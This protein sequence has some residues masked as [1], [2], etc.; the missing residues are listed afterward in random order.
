MGQSLRLFWVAN[1]VGDF[2]GHDSGDSMQKLARWQHEWHITAEAEAKQAIATGF[3]NS[4]TE[5]G[6]DP[7][8]AASFLDC[9]NGDEFWRSFRK[10][11]SATGPLSPETGSLA[12]LKWKDWETFIDGMDENEAFNGR[13]FVPLAGEWRAD[14]SA[15][16][17]QIREKRDWVT[18]LQKSQW[19]G[20]FGSPPAWS[21]D[22]LVGFM[23]CP[24]GFALVQYVI[25]L[26]HKMRSNLPEDAARL[27]LESMLLAFVTILDSNFDHLES[28]NW[29]A[30]SFDIAV[31]LNLEDPKFYPRYSDYIAS[32]DSL[33]LRYPT[34]REDLP[35]AGSQIQVAKRLKQQL[36]EAFRVALVGEHG[37]SNLENLAAVQAATDGFISSPS[38]HTIEAV[39]FF[40]YMWQLKGL[41]D[42]ASLSSSRI[43]W[44]AF[45][46]QPLTESAGRDKLRDQPLWTIQQAVWSL[47][48]FARRD[49]F[50][51]TSKVIICSEPL[52]L[53]V[54]LHAALHGLPVSPSRLLTRA[55]AA[56]RVMCLLVD[57]DQVFGFDEVDEFWTLVET[58]AFG[59]NGAGGSNGAVSAT[60]RMT[61]EMLRWQAG[62]R[63]PYVPCLSLYISARYQPTKPDMLFFRSSLPG[64][65]PFLRVLRLIEAENEA[66]G[67]GGSGSGVNID[68]MTE[69]MTFSEMASYR[70]IAMLPHIPN[71]LRLSDMYCIGIP[72]F[73]PDEPMIHK[74]IWPDDPLPLL[75]K[76]R[77][78]AMRGANTSELSPLDFQV[79]GRRYYQFR[80]ER[81][82]WLQ[83]T[84]W[85]VRPHLLHF[86]SARDLLEKAVLFSA[87][88]AASVSRKM[89]KQQEKLKTEVLDF[90]RFA[91]TSALGWTRM[92]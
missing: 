19:Q 43:S 1:C 72:L 10:A 76:I 58:T 48:E 87:E 3:A 54:L 36:M 91:L 29:N 78:P 12:Y 83:Y 5:K 11:Y 89:R 34:W 17:T 86:S 27:N 20:L 67:S 33:P 25:F 41:S 85:W 62:I 68:T 63:V 66:R 15:F 92:E 26:V 38:S 13:I 52:W 39:H 44:D 40:S 22:N 55:S 56:G 69:S 73:I 74:F 7:L 81:H 90:W 30:S 45:W 18:A 49:A 57:F 51:R 6:T 59:R 47:R 50:L 53:C 31:N 37:P 24:V 16:F 71:A 4:M 46:G 80:R 75:S 8:K 21:S 60:S 2:Q 42:S 14:G 82:Y 65:S 64:A 23:L 28:S 77:M 70:S 88:E 84:E 61:A 79:A 9:E 35:Q 32:L